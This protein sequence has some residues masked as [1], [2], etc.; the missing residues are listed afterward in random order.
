MESS[1]KSIEIVSENRRNAAI[2]L[3]DNIQEN[4]NMNE[5]KYKTIIFIPSSF[6]HKRQ[7]VSEEK[8]KAFI[9]IPSSFIHN[10]IAE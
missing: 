10:N 5:E 9:F 2:R 6:I 3:T 1:N 8:Y 7:E 4:D